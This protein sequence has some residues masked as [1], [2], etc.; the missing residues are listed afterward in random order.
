MYRP[1]RSYF[2]SPFLYFDE[3]RSLGCKALGDIV[4]KYTNEGNSDEVMKLVKNILSS[5]K[6]TDKGAYDKKP[7]NSVWHPFTPNMFIIL[8][9]N[10]SSSNGDEDD[11]SNMI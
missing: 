9:D 1:Q 5:G 8:R 10:A 6:A 4:S 11:S 7:P 3:C 2:Q